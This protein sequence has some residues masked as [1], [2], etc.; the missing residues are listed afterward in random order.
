MPNELKT[1]NSKPKTARSAPRDPNIDHPAV[2]MH[3]QIVRLTANHIQRR[4]IVA[5]IHWATQEMGLEADRAL[6]IWQSVLKNYMLEGKRPTNVKY[7]LDLYEE[8]IRG[9]KWDRHNRNR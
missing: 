4:E 1:E 7:M 9:P 6:L 2:R 8:K 3:R 5:T